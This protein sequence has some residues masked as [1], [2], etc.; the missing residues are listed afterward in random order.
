MSSTLKRITRDGDGLVAD[1][2]VEYKFTDDGLIDWRK[3][4]KTEFLVPNKSRTSETDVT[5]LKDWQ[6]I[7]L[8]GG[9]KELAQ[10]RTKQAKDDYEKFKI[11][12]FE[13]MAALKLRGKLEVIDK[14]GLGDVFNQ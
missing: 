1:G 3:M 11:G 8:L 9:I 6:L 14:A 2:S 12:C 4:I 13:E 7:I 10:I 5:K